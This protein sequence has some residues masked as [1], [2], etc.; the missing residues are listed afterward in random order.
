MKI[1]T[2][3]TFNFQ[4]NFRIIQTLKE[5]SDCYT[6]IKFIMENNIDILGTQEMTFRKLNMCMSLLSDYGYQIYGHGRLGKLGL[7]FPFCLANETNALIFKGQIPQKGETLK[8]P[9][10]GSQFPR[11]ITKMV[12]DDFV[13]LNTHLDY[14]N[15]K[16]KKKQLEYIYTLI[17]NLKKQGRTIILTGDFN[18][19]LKNKHF[20]KFVKNL[21]KL[22]LKRVLI[23][24]NTCKSVK[25]GPID[26]I[27]IPNHCLVEKAYL[28]E[29]S[30]SDHR[31]LV[32]KIKMED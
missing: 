27:F 22:G 21:E 1:L 7:I 19:T 8:L 30:I 24:E 6:F 23:N 3:G 9:W 18:L 32:V 4:N 12:F 11:I 10:F 5:K 17:K 15:S 20:Q 28:P 31:P 14:L 16:I 2:I 25:S 13:F 26:H 29:L